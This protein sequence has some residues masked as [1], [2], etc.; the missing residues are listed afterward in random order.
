MG[1]ERN[2]AVK[3]AVLGVATGHAVYHLSATDRERFAAGCA[4]HCCTGAVAMLVAYRY[5]AAPGYASVRCGRAV[6][7]E[8]G[9]TFAERHGL[10][11]LKQ[12]PPP[13][14]IDDA[15]MDTLV[16]LDAELAELDELREGGLVDAGTPPAAEDQSGERRADGVE[17]ELGQ[18]RRDRIAAQQLLDA[19]TTTADSVRGLLAQATLLGVDEGGAFAMAEQDTVRLRQGLERLA[20]HAGALVS[21]AAEHRRGYRDLD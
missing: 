8:H 6:C 3:A 14:A 11:V 16:P 17:V 9:T 1:G 12:T 10:V 15:I 19:V 7:Y 5:A 2:G 20:F 13:R 18:R 21:I 4:R